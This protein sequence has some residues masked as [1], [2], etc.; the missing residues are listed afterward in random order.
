MNE[1][2]TPLRDWRDAL[3]AWVIH[4]PI[5]TRADVDMAMTQTRDVLSADL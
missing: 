2:Y 4:M 1:S 3:M 5:L